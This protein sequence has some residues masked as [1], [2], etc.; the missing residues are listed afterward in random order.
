MADVLNQDGIQSLV[1]EAAVSRM[2]G[3]RVA[4]ERYDIRMRHD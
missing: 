1:K 3:G 2:A 4:S